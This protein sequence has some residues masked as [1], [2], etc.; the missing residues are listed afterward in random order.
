VNSDMLRFTERTS[1]FE[2]DALG[3]LFTNLRPYRRSQ[4]GLSFRSPRAHGPLLSGSKAN[5][6]PL[7]ICI[8]NWFHG[9]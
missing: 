1:E 7:S 9:V 4:R 2:N 8:V 6:A 3:Q 5:V